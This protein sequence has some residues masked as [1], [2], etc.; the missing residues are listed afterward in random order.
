MNLR[1]IGMKHFFYNF[2]YNIHKTEK[3]IYTEQVTPSP[4]KKKIYYMELLAPPFSR[5]FSR[6]AESTQP[7]PD[8]SQ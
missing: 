3:N 5:D 1:F 8:R 6:E 7:P 2:P 4:P